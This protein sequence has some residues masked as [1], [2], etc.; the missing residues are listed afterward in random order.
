MRLSHIGVTKMKFSQIDVI[1]KEQ[2]LIISRQKNKK[3]LVRIVNHV[4]NR[5]PIYTFYFGVPT[6]TFMRAKAF[7]EDVEQQ[8]DGQF[9]PSDLAKVLFKDFLEY[10]RSTNNVDAIFKKLQ[11]RDISPTIIMRK[12]ESELLFEEHRGFEIMTTRLNHRDALRGEYLLRDMLDIYK[13][14]SFTLENILEIIFRDFIDDYRRGF[15][16]DPYNKV[17]KYV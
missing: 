12:H 14:H 13:D 8:I 5:N 11:A 15:I 1:G 2:Q 6:Y 3:V 4:L 7:C 16:K 10:H 9:S 17:I